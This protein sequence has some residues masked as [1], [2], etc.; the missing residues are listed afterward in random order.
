MHKASREHSKIVN[1]AK[2]AEYS[3]SSRTELSTAV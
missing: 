2:A 1:I 3:T